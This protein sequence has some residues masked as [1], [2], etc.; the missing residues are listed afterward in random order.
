VDHLRLGRVRRQPRRPAENEQ[1]I[2]HRQ[3][4]HSSQQWYSDFH[5]LRCDGAVI[6]RKSCTQAWGCKEEEP[7]GPL[8]GQDNRHRKTG[9]SCSFDLS[10]TI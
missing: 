5:D 2:P 8:T 3:S 9:Q 4:F 6:R 10:L 7:K 1:D